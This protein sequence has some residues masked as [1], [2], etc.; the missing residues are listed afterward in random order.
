MPS[1]GETPRGARPLPERTRRVG[2]GLKD[3]DLARCTR[4][5]IRPRLS[6]F[7]VEDLER[8][9]SI[10]DKFLIASGLFVEHRVAVLAAQ[11]ALRTRLGAIDSSGQAWAHYLALEEVVNARAATMV[12]LIVPWAFREG[13]RSCRG[14]P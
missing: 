8:L 6:R 14:R 11:E 7:D 13:A 5:S 1:V 9:A 2:A 4:V 3:R 12:E 10:V